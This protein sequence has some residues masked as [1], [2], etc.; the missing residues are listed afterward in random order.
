MRCTHHSTTQ[1]TQ[2]PVT[3]NHNN[4][5]YTLLHNTTHG[6]ITTQ[7]YTCIHHITTQHMDPS[8]HNTSHAYITSQHNTWIHHNTTLHMHTS[9]YNTTHTPITP[10][11]NTQLHRIR[12]STAQHTTTLHPSLRNTILHIT[13]HPKTQHTTT[14]HP[15]LHNTTH[16]PITPHH[17]YQGP[18]RLIFS[19]THHTLQIILPFNYFQSNL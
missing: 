15:S 7:H 1:L 11:H 19:C 10:Q 17:C 6:S 4:I 3:P 2:Q 18:T 12:H 5:L 13:H 14:L 16:T 9:L 8:Q